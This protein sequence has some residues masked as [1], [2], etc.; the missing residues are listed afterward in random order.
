MSEGD[1]DGSGADEEVVV[2]ELMGRSG[3][4]VSGPWFNDGVGGEEPLRLLPASLLAVG[5]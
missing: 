1:K 3:M 5:G 4:V 2:S